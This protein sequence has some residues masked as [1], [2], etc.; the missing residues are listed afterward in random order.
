[1]LYPCYITNQ[2]PNT[3]LVILTLVLC[4]HHYSNSNLIKDS[5]FEVRKTTYFS[6]EI[7]FKI[8]FVY[9]YSACILFGCLLYNFFPL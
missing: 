9:F 4:K 3:N 5:S 2:P 7:I 8:F 1:M 6:L